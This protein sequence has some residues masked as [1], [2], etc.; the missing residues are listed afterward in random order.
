MTLPIPH[1]GSQLLAVREMPHSGR[2]DQI[3]YA[4]GISARDMGGARNF[5][6][7]LADAQLDVL[8]KTNKSSTL[9]AVS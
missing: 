2:P 8:E 7:S 6:E 4:F 1:A 3:L 5:I 9:K